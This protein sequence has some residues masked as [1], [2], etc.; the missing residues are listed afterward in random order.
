MV[1][2]EMVHYGLST[3]KKK[4]KKKNRCTRVEN[5]GKRV[6]E[7]CAKIP[8]GGRGQEFQEK[9]PGGVHLFFFFAFLLASFSKICLG[10]EYCFIPPLT[11]PP[12]CIY[13]QN[14]A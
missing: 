5:S 4:K 1:K 2:K 7:V 9:L 6:P 3:L 12:V 8:G 10:R 11:P 14:P 13:G